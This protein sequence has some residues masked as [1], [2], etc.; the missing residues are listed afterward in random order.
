LK[1]LKTK[2]LS[3]I[4][5]I[6]YILNICPLAFGVFASDSVWKEFYVSAE[7]NDN[8]DGS[9]E[10]P[11]RTIAEA[12]EA[13]RNISDQMSGDIV[14]NILPGTYEL[15]EQL[16][17]SVADSGKNGYKVIYRGDKYNP[18]VI[19]GGQI[20]TGFTPMPGNSKIYQAYVD[21]D[22]IRELYINGER[23]FMAQT[24]KPVK[25]IKRDESL[26]SI[27]FYNTY[28]NAPKDEYAFYDPDTIYSYDGFYVSKDDLGFYENPEDIEIFA[29]R[30]FREALFHVQNIEQDPQREDVL[31]VRMK[32]NE[33]DVY[34]R[35]VDID[36]ASIPEKPFY[37]RN[38]MELLDQ[39]GE[40]YYNKKT[41]FLYYMPYEDED[42]DS[43]QVI[44]PELDQAINA[45]GN[46]LDDRISN[47]TFEN[48]EF[49]Y[50]TL[51]NIGVDKAPWHS[52]QA[53]ES[54]LGNSNLYTQAA[55][56]V[57]LADSINFYGNVFHSMG[58]A[59]IDMKNAVNN[60]NIDGNCF[61]DTGSAAIMVGTALHMYSEP[62]EEYY[63][64]YSAN[65]P[66]GR[67]NRRQYIFIRQKIQYCVGI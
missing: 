15:E 17:F 23:R 51:K 12:Q 42:L 64:F 62:G 45:M 9:R 65:Y 33:Y 20:V 35:T 63:A 56:K 31:I 46:T 37:I 5:I 7:G 29:H 41:K 49:A 18:P 21:T 28:T 53:T 32:N 34:K 60:S 50:Y 22:C 8:A 61:Y 11:F 43:A 39:P 2:C 4:L 59:A 30:Y 26:L 10:N 25:G 6:L 27:S 55:I 14:V 24:N 19:S 13:V 52:Q 16:E 48:L 1:T 3:L 57:H 47:I 38:A 36:M 54:V 67:R 58:G 44:V 66:P 40:F